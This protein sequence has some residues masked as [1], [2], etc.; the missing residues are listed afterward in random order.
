MNA[1]KTNKIAALNDFV[2][3]RLHIQYVM[4]FIYNIESIRVNL[5]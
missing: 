2:S 4:Y 3:P 1:F 5:F